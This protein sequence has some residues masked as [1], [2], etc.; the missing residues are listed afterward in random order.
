MRAIQGIAHLVYGF[1]GIALLVLAGPA[2][3]EPILQF[4]KL[5]C[6]SSVCSDF[7]EVQF[8]EPVQYFFQVDNVGD[9]SFT[10]V[11]ISDPDLGLD[12]EFGS[13]PTNQGFAFT[14]NLYY[15]DPGTHS[16]I[17]LAIG[18]TEADGSFVYVDTAVVDVLAPQIPQPHPSLSS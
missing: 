4:T 18:E 11:L 5:A 16:N 13:L 10:S 8:G 3:A 2:R 7:I 6:D 15:L 14:S 1:V 9:V 17:A 12:V